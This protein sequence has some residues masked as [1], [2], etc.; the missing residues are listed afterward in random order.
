RNID[1]IEISWAGATHITDSAE[2]ARGLAARIAAAFH[3]PVENVEPGL[4]VGSPQDMRRKLEA[5]LA[6]GV[7][8]FIIIPMGPNLTTVRRFYEEVA[9][10]FRP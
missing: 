9:A 7:S 4:F 10:E 6:V 5:L 3:Q 1:E 2:E 8:H